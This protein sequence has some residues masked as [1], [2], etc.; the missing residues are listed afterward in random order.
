MELNS[1]L[2]GSEDPSRLSS[3]YTKLFGEPIM[4]QE[5]FS[6]WQLGG[7]WLVVGPHDE[8]KGTNAQPGRLMWNLQSADVLGDFEK[9]KGAGATVVREPAHPGDETEG[10]IATLS[11]PDGNFF[12]LMSPMEM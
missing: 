3:Y 8:V 11:D 12:Q 9:L 1:I 5:G 4:E 2:I 6:G 10:Y 7:G